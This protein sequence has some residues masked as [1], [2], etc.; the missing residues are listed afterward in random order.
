MDRLPPVD[1]YI[2]GCPPFP[3]MTIF[4]G[5]LQQ[6]GRVPVPSINRAI[7]LFSS[8]FQDKEFLKNMALQIVRFG[9]IFLFFCCRAVYYKEYGS[10][11]DKAKPRD[12][13]PRMFVFFV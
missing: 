5:L 2:P 8:F 12:C 4:E 1:F 7:P 10:S 11:A 9:I 6:A 13:G 3:A